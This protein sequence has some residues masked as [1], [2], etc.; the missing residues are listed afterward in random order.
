MTCSKYGFAELSEFLRQEETE[1]V[2]ATMLKHLNLCADCRQRLVELEEILEEMPR[3]LRLVQPPGSLRERTLST[4]FRLRSPFDAL[5]EEQVGQETAWPIEQIQEPER[6]ESPSTVSL[7][8][9]STRRT[10]TRRSFSLRFGRLFALT[11][12]A[13]F[14]VASVLSVQLLQ[15]KRQVTELTTRLANVEVNSFALKPTGLA[16]RAVGKAILERKGER[17]NVYLLL[18]GTKPTQGNQVYHVWLWNHGN[19]ISAGVF[20]VGSSGQAVFKSSVTGT[21][22]GLSG[23]GITLEPNASTTT[24]KGPKVFGAQL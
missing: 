17:L 22:S 5:H 11:S 10:P 21:W 3:G 8:S 18:D 13:L 12:V 2:Q 24:P 14:A 1:E 4:A 9:M 15:A 23:I 20:T 6:E 19:R 16:Q 7:G